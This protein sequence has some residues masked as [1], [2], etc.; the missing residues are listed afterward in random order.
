MHVR[1]I[2]TNQGGMSLASGL[3]FKISLLRNE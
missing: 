3:G 1:K 2:G